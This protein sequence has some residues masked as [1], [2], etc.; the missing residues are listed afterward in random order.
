MKLRFEHAFLIC[1][2]DAYRRQKGELA[3]VYG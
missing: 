1:L 2:L 3:D